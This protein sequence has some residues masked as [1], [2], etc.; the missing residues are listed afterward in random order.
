MNLKLLT[1]QKTVKHLINLILRKM[2]LSK[3]I[4][5]RFNPKNQ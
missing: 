5:N 3:M 4:E 1:E 2:S